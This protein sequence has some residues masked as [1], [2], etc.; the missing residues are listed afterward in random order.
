MPVT[1]SL[2][3]AGL[4]AQ[5]DYGNYDVNKTFRYDPDMRMTWSWASTVNFPGTNLLRLPPTFSR[6]LI[7]LL[8]FF[9]AQCT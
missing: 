6:R 2:H 1:I 9:T 3:L 4:Q 7:L 5:A 8:S